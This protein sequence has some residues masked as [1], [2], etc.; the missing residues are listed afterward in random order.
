MDGLNNTSVSFL[1]V[2]PKSMP[3]KKVVTRATWACVRLFAMDVDG[4]LTDGTVLIS[5]DGTEA[6]A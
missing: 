2:Y 1:R 5:S 4:I 6:K 3:A